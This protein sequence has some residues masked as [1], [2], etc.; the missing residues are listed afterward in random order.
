MIRIAAE[1][2]NTLGEAAAWDAREGRLLWLDLVEPA[3]FGYAPATKAASRLALDAP[4][5]LGPVIPT[6]RPGTLLLAHPAGL[7]LLD[8]RTGGLT[9]FVAPEQ[10]RAGLLYN[11]GKVD[12]WGRL[13]IG[14][15][16]AAEAEPRGVLWCLAPGAAPVMADA[17]FVV[18]NGPA[19]SP[20]GRTL[21]FSDS[22]GRRILA[23]DIAPDSPKPTGRRVFASFAMDE[24]L[25]DGLAVDAEGGVWVAHWDGW[26]IT[27]FSPE[28][29]RLR[30]I[31]LPVPRVTS[32]AF[33]DPGLATLY[34]TTARLDLS[35]VMLAAAPLSGHLFAIDAGVEGLEDRPF[36][37]D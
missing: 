9:P 37:L 28:G 18:S 2:A 29:E 36:P 16:D 5:P 31:L 6:G 13:W 23:Y 7:S 3:L 15:S 24:G 11:D 12:R 33:G 21:Y 19:F 10:G 25:P 26:R 8:A 30:V 4:T 27:R 35:P 32:L 20:D 17:G 34:V 1:C 22:I 14:T